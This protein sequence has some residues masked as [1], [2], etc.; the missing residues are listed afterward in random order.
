[1]VRERER[2]SEGVDAAVAVEASKDCNPREVP[3][4]RPVPKPRAVLAM[5]VLAAGVAAVTPAPPPAPPA[6]PAVAKGV[7]VMMGVA[8]ASC[9]SGTGSMGVCDRGP[10]RFRAA[11][12]GVTMG[13]EAEAEAEEDD[14]AAAAAVVEGAK[15]PPSW[16]S[17]L[18]RP[19]LWGAP[20]VLAPMAS[21]RSKSGSA[22]LDMSPQLGA[23]GLARGCGP[24][25]P[26]KGDGRCA[27]ALISDNPRICSAVG[28]LDGS[29]DSIC[30]VCVVCTKAIM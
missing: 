8:R 24:V 6:A 28:R 23:A 19:A 9:C 20:V 22:R 7:G 5:G 18:R 2:E 29:L 16:E 30:G 21:S 13:P 26:R 14:C 4:P 12:V 15:P 10:A 25:A 3:S 11:A 27:A 1:M 17:P